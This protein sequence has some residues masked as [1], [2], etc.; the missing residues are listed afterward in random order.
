MGINQ[1]GRGSQHHVLGMEEGDKTTNRGADV[2]DIW[3]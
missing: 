3:G 2:G 1:A